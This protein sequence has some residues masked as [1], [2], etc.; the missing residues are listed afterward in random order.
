MP[1]ARRQRGEQVAAAY[2]AGS[3]VVG[4]RADV[5]AELSVAASVLALAASLG[6]TG[7]VFQ[8]LLDQGEITY[9]VP[10]AAAILLVSLGSDYNIFL[11]GRIWDEARRRPL[12]DAVRVA[13]SRA[14]T[15]ITIAGLVLAGSFALLALVPVQPFREL[16]FAMA[17]GLLI[18]AFLVRTLFVP[19]LITLVGERS[20]WPGHRLATARAPDSSSAAPAASVR[21]GA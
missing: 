5:A 9:F 8:G 17:A 10:F 13:G 15:P 12:R 16:A 21:P 14:A 20:G 11:V 1:V 6:L 19:A 18:D 4:R 2:G 3:E 7:Y